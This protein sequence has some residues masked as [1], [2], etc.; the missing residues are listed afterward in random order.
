MQSKKHLYEWAKLHATSHCLG[1]RISE[2]KMVEA[3]NEVI[4]AWD[5]LDG[6]PPDV[7]GVLPDRYYEHF[8]MVRRELMAAH[9]AWIING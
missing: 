1:T 2:K 9:Y 5:N 6:E 8:Y 7:Y 4:N 3:I